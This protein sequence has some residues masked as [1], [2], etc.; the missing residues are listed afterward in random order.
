MQ[1]QIN[2]QI[3]KRIQINSS[4]FSKRVVNRKEL[5]I[6]DVIQLLIAIRQPILHNCFKIDFRI[7]FICQNPNLRLTIN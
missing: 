3:C 6:R 2:L 5:I 4:R 1:M 7:R